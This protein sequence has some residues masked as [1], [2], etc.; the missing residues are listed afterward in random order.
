MKRLFELFIHSPFYPHWL[1]FRNFD[2][3]EKKLIRSFS[4]KVL[5]VGCGSNPKKEYCLQTNRKVTSYVTSDSTGWDNE[6]RKLADRAHSHGFITELLYGATKDINKV[7]IVCDA[8]NLPFKKKSFDTYCCFGVF[9]HISNPQQFF[10]EAHRVLKTGGGMYFSSPFMYREHGTPGQ[11]FQRITKAGFHEFA[12]TNGFKIDFIY[13]N[14]FFGATIASMINQYII[15]KIAEK[16]IIVK[17]ILFLFSP[18][19]FFLTNSIGFILDL[20]DRDERFSTMYYL[21]L[22]SK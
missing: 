5:E 8:L 7:D 15:R 22:T 10:K 14:A 13:T 16:N 6:F 19:I 2:D 4:G 9:E 11:D 12:Q 17:I 1:E 3:G 21:K 18:F 20:I